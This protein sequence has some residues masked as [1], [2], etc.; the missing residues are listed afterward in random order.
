MPG[1]L[2]ITDNRTGKSHE[3]LIEN[4]T[5]NTIDRRKIRPNANDFGLMADDPGFRNMAG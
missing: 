3:L 2:T 5:I 1:T 4:H